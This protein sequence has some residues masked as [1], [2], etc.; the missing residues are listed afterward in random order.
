[1]TT[2]LLYRVT[3]NGGN[4]RAGFSNAEDAQ[5]F[6][7][8]IAERWRD[9]TEVSSASGLIGQYDRNGMPTPEFRGRGDE[10]YPAGPR[11]KE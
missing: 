1:M 9:F 8:Y 10:V 4:R 3:Y 7:Q 2:R 11:P 6:A 5:M